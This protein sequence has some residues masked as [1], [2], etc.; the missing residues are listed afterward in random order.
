MAYANTFG[1]RLKSTDNIACLML[2]AVV[3]KSNELML[4]VF[5]L[6]KPTLLNIPRL[7]QA[8]RVKDVANCQMK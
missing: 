2:S 6:K 8:T 3:V 4:L 7:T 1:S 5:G